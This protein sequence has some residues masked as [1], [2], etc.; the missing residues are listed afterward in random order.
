MNW[1]KKTLPVATMQTSPKM[2]VVNHSPSPQ[3]NTYSLNR[4]SM[5]KVG[6]GGNSIYENDSILKKPFLQ[7]KKTFKYY[8]GTTVQC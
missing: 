5:E 4:E 2:Q 6:S 1:R 8:L 3:S 7:V